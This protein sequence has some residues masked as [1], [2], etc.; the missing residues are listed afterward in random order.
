ML[1]LQ[2]IVIPPSGKLIDHE[3]LINMTDAVLDGWLTHGRYNQR[4]EETFL[5]F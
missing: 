3:E 2:F 4:F 5:I 1:L